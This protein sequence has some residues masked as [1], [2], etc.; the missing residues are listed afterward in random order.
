LKS[1]HPS[2]PKFHTYVVFNI[3]PQWQ[4]IIKLGG[5]PNRGAAVNS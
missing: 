2:V 4:D 5:W 1:Q 3:T